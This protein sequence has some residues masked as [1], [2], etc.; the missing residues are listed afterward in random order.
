MSILERLKATVAG[1]KLTA[2]D[3]FEA[4]CVAGAELAGSDR[5]SALALEIAIRLLEARR[6]NLLPDGGE[7]VVEYLAEECGLYPYVN[8]ENF[9]HM[10]QTLIESHSI[11]GRQKIHLHAKQMQALLWLLAGD[12]VVLSAPTSFGKSALV[13]AFITKKQPHLIV[14]IMPTIALIDETRR[15]M[16][17]AFGRK[18]IIITDALEEHDPA[19]PTIFILTPRATIE[20]ALGRQD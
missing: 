4:V 14:M 16:S 5:E 1:E 7:T 9:G 8:P 20:Q 18:Y 6:E 3:V 15:R 12:N 13:D 19:F 2:D 10:S 11:D 17:A